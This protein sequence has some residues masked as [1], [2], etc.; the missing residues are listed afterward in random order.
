MSKCKHILNG[1]EVQISEKKAMRHLGMDAALLMENAALEMKHVIEQKHSLNGKALLM[2]GPGNNGGDG[3]A[4]AR[5]LIVS[6]FDVDVLMVGKPT[7]PLAKMNASILKKMNANVSTKLKNKKYDLIVDA[8]YGVGLSKALSKKIIALLNRVNRLRSYKYS[9]DI[10]TGLDATTGIV[11]DACFKADHTLS[12]GC[13]KIGF[14]LKDGPNVTGQISCLNIGLHPDW[15]RS[16]IVEIS[17]EDFDFNAPSY[18]LNTH[19]GQFGHA[20]I[21]AGSLAYSG[22]AVLS[23]KACMRVGAGLCTVLVP[24]DAHTI[25]KKQLLEPMSIAFDAKDVHPSQV[26]LW[27][28]N[29]SAILIGPGLVPKAE[30]LS[31]F[32]MIIQY[33]KVPVV[34]DASALSFIQGRSMMNKIKKISCVLTPHPKECGQ[35]LGLKSDEVQSMRVECIKKLKKMYHANVV[36]K[37]AYSLIH[38]EGKTIYLNPVACSALSTAGSGDVLSGMIVGLIAQGMDELKSCLRACYWHGQLG[39]NL[40]K[41]S[42]K[43]RTMIASDLIKA[44]EQNAV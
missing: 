13:Q 1:K 42:S 27:L 4:L 32:D 25:I 5:Q 6:G 9:V 21:V 20:L 35:L 29:K 24:K 39:L 3:Y 2:C 23:A 18:G 34:I 26:K 43:S 15:F 12:L 14:F 8:I 11:K 17:C 40:E 33:A 41:K 31:L 7:S 19:K 38:S 36:L 22:A 10:P 44:M 37:G 30:V 28:R 16:D